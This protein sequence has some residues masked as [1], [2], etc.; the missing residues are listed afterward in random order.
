LQELGRQ[1]SNAYLTAKHIAAL[2]AEDFLLNCFCS[3]CSNVIVSSLFVFKDILFRDALRNK[4]VNTNTGQIKAA[5]FN[6][7]LICLVYQN[8]FIFFILT[9]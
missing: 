8:G 2:M 9:S 5:K 7:Y 3:R 1:F 4:L 6:Y